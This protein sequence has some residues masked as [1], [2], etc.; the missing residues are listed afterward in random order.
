M[1]WKPYASD[2]EQSEGWPAI[3]LSQGTVAASLQGVNFMGVSI[4]LLEANSQSQSESA[5][6][7]SQ[8]L[9][10]NDP[11]K[12]GILVFLILFFALAAIAFFVGGIL[13]VHVNKTVAVAIFATSGG[14]LKMV[15]GIVRMLFG[16]PPTTITLR[17]GTAG[18]VRT[19]DTKK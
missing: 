1:E 12:T 10:Q 13:T 5:Q 18:Q 16:Y 14:V 8:Q 2:I 3:T 11:I 19:N 17:I 7:L 9:I 6:K 15:Y 4:E